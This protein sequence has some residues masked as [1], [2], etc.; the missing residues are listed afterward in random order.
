MN[1]TYLKE[2]QKIYNTLKHKNN[3]CSRRNERC[4]KLHI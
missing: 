4:N 1:E 3:I 2:T